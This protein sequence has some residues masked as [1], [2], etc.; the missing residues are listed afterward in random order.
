MLIITELSEGQ[1]FLFLPVLLVHFLDVVGIVYFRKIFI[2]ELFNQLMLA[3]Q[4]HIDAEHYHDR[5][6]L[7]LSL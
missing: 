1:H 2:N 4:L 3:S 7:L 6:L 5:F